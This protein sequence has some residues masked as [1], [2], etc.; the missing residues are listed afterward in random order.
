MIDGTPLVVLDV[1]GGEA[2]EATMRAMEEG[3]AQAILG[4]AVDLGPIA[5]SSTAI[6]EVMHHAAQMDIQAAA[7]R[8]TSALNGQLLPALMQ[9]HFPIVTLAD[10]PRSVQRAFAKMIRGA[11]HTK[12]KLQK[13]MRRHD[14]TMKRLQQR[15]DG[16]TT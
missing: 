3:M 8:L 10:A 15:L 13:A 4:A 14:R 16:A 2:F 12:R 6:Y 11:Y 9:Q 7:K 5:P 1:I